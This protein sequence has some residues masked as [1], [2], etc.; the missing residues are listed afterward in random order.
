VRL[1][2]S[3]TTIASSQIANFENYDG[4]AAITSYSFAFGGATN[5]TAGIIAGPTV[6]GDGSATPVLAI[7]AGHTGNYGLSESVTNASVWGEGFSF[8][9]LDASNGPGCLNA[10]AYK[11]ISL[12]VR[13]LVPSGVF[14]I[15]LS[16]AQST[17]PDT[18]TTPTSGGSCTGTVAKQTCQAPIKSGIPITTDWTQVTALWQDFTR[19]LAGP[20]IPLP[21]NG[22]DITGFTFSAGLNF[23]PESPGSTVYVAV[24]GDVSFSIDDLAF[25]Q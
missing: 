10:S 11:G 19:G 1:C 5:G 6:L 9:P 22:D 12:W 15:T 21:P 8:F 24:P 4:S 3:K 25:I 16:M 23:V 17:E 13:G 20:G 14:A 2:T 18:T 7:L